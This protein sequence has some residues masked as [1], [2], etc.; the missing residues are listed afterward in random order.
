MFRKTL[1]AFLLVLLTTVFAYPDAELY[2][3]DVKDVEIMQPNIEYLRWQGS[4]S[5]TI[6]TRATIFNYMFCI[7][8]VGQYPEK[9]PYS[10]S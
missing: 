8:E 9:D 6:G 2:A 7:W 4:V 1:F 3:D 5:P 10:F